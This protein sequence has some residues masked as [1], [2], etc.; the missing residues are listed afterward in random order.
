MKPNWV[1]R[2]RQLLMLAA[3]LGLL[4][5]AGYCTRY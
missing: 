3:L 4:L 5:A 2:A 1:T